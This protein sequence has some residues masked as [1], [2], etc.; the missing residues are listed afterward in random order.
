MGNQ[1][2]SQLVSKVKKAKYWKTLKKYF[3]RN[4]TSDEEVIKNISIAIAAYESSNEFAQF[5]SKYDYWLQGKASLTYLELIGFAVFERIDKGNCAACHTLKKAH[6]DDNP[7]FTDFTYDNI[8]VPSNPNNPFY[9]IDKRYNPQG[10][11]YIDYGL[12]KS[13]RMKDAKYLGMFK[14]PTL[15]NIELTSPYMHNGVFKTLKEVVEFYNS[16]DLE[17]KWGKPEVPFNVNHKELGDLQLTEIDIDALVA[18]MLT[19]TDGYKYE[20]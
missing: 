14:V 10:A 2:I 9:T 4:N 20:K 13:P 5:S 3:K 19:L 16:R 6:K 11:T 17:S 7:L 15:R 8:G 1:S 18:F 12:G